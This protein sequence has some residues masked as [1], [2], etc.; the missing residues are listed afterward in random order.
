MFTIFNKFNN[1]TAITTFA[2]CAK[3]ANFDAGTDTAGAVVPVRGHS[4][5]DVCARRGRGTG[6]DSARGDA[7]EN[8]MTDSDRG[9]TNDLADPENTT[10]RDPDR[11][12]TWNTIDRA[13]DVDEVLDKDDLENFFI[14]PIPNPL[15]PGATSDDPG[16]TRTS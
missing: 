12:S 3:C 8:A 16:A 13:V 2:R 4:S 7:E 15:D 9:D 14:E 1:F 11:N 10:M 5:D 6:I